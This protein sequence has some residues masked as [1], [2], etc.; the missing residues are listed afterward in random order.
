MKV[1]I[2]PIYQIK[3][4]NTDHIIQF[5]PIKYK[6]ILSN[7]KIVF[8]GMNLKT[9][10]IIN[11]MNEIINKY[12]TT[13]DIKF[14]LWSILLKKKFGKNYNSYIQ[15]LESINFITLISNYYVGKKCKTYKLT[16]IESTL[17]LTRIK[18]TDKVLIKKYSKEHL[19]KSFLEINESPI[20]IELRH[21]LVDDLYQV[22]IDY[23]AS[24][25]FI[26]KLFADGKIDK[27]KQIRN[28]QSIEGI[29]SGN[30]FFKFDE[31]GR[32][33]TNFTT[34]RKEIR[35][36]FL[37]INN[38]TLDE[39]DVKNSQPLFFTLLLIKE[40]GI[41]Q[42]DKECVNFID[43]VRN[44]LIYDDLLK[45]LKLKSR[46]DAKILMYKVLFGDNTNDTDENNMF[47]K[48]YPSIFN[49]I[50]ELK[51]HNQTYKEFS[52]QLQKMESNF[53]FNQVAQ[54]LKNRFPS[55][56]FFT[57]HDSIIFPKSYKEEVKLVFN[58]Y[59][60]KLIN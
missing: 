37:F 7:K 43:L 55:I 29:N 54:E 6:E 21:K 40:Y 39:I 53:I 5:I 47:N 35:K 20:N 17:N 41:E 11:M 3:S 13:Y 10:I 59:M 46:E 38:D 56:V 34:L 18:I 24:I 57:V 58:Y 45:K 26:N 28:I 33:H 8:N 48:I 52:H 42:L 16:D 19:R 31:Y 32:L 22:N 60:K 4:G 2:T 51:K 36:N 25:N 50:V 44:G 1:S 15:Y 30:I 9:D 23:D 12:I 27:E 49:Y 14:D